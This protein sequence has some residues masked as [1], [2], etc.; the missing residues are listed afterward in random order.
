MSAAPDGTTA[1]ATEQR[2]QSPASRAGSGEVAGTSPNTDKKRPAQ[3][4]PFVSSQSGAYFRLIFLMLYSPVI[5][6]MAG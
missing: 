3:G 5:S 4:R 1:A 2:Q 6:R